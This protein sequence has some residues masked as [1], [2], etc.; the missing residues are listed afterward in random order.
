[1]N[2][3]RQKPKNLKDKL[4][5]NNALTKTISVI[6][7]ILIIAGL[8][9]FITIGLH[10][11]N[12]LVIP[13]FIRNT[14]F[15]GSGTGEQTAA[16]DSGIYDFL[17][18]ERPDRGGFAVDIS[19]ESVRGLISVTV[20]PDN[21]YLETTAEY[22]SDGNAARTVEIS[23]WKKE[24]KHKYLLKNNRLPEEL[25]INNGVSEY[26]ENYITQNSDV[27]RAVAGTSFDFASLP[28][29]NDINFYLDLIVSGEITDYAINRDIEGN[30]LVITYKTAELG[31]REEIEISLESGLV[32][33]VQSYFGDVLFYKSVTSV[34]E[35]YFTGNE[36]ENT[37]LGEN[38]FVIG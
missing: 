20:M 12:L 31:Q 5:E 8:F 10:S 26:Y 22:Y 19:L 6:F 15:Y 34:I 29:I 33:S 23:L 1:M 17:D 32:L 38:I 28:H 16:D 35:A 11:L 14:F 2:S 7:L 3:N 4:K 13:D 18:S 24:E 37:V 25:Y 30:I 21:L 27:R 36:P 9:A